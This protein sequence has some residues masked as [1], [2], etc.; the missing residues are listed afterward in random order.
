MIVAQFD[1]AQIVCAGTYEQ[2]WFETSAADKNLSM[3]RLT[4]NFDGKFLDYLLDRI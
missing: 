2:S 1:L 4:E 3:L